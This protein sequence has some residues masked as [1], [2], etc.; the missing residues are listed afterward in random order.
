MILLRRLKKCLKN[1]KTIPDL[2]RNMSYYDTCHLPS[3]YLDM[4]YRKV[5]NDDLSS[6]EI[7]DIV[8]FRGDGSVHKTGSLK[9]LLDDLED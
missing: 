8:E 9:E 3:L 7:Q 1:L 6:S 4:M 2:N 5:L